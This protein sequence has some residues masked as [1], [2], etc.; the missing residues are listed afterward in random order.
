[1]DTRLD[2][3]LCV[4][5]LGSDEQGVVELHFF[6][7]REEVL[8]RS[9]RLRHVAR[10]RITP[11]ERV[12]MKQHLLFICSGNVNRSPTAESLFSN[13]R[14]YE[15]R[16]AGTDQDAVVRVSQE[17]IDWA[18]FVF[19]MSEKEDGHLAFLESNFSVKDKPVFDLD[20]P[21]DYDRDDPELI[22]LLRNKIEGFMLLRGYPV[23]G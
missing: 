20:I 10:E 18:D 7:N 21:D 3:Y 19:V 9:A 22:G 23:N 12:G 13:S 5:L 15:A 8:I 16:S 2:R 17:M 4:H 14:F 1:M 6:P 11:M